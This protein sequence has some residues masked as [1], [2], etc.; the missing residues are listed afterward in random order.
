M[1]SYYD[2]I[3]IKSVEE[4]KIN[5]T[6]IS[7]LSYY[8]ENLSKHFLFVGER[9]DFNNLSNHKFVKSEQRD[10]SFDAVNFIKKLIEEK[11][12]SKDDAIIY[13]GD[14]LTENGYEFYLN[15]LLKIVPFL[16]NEIPQHHYFLSKDFKKI[17]YISF[18]NEIEFGGVS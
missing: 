7:N 16:V 11:I 6:V 17:I 10:I 5:Y 13:I 18:E 2:N 12:C 4:Q 3:L 8:I 14:S 1:N 15:D 9:L